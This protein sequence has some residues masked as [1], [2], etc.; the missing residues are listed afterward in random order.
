MLEASSITS[1]LRA[2][3]G[4]IRLADHDP[5]AK[6]GFAGGKRAGE[7]AL[8][9][10]APALSDLKERLFAHRHRRPAAVLLI[11]Q[12]MDTSGK[13]GTVK[14]VLRSGNRSGVRLASFKKPTEEELQHDFLWRIEKQ[15][16][17]LG[18]HRRV[19]PIAVRGRAGRA[20]ASAG[21]I[22]GG[23]AG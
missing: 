6:P 18:F 20:G 1:L 21:S 17:E 10:L 8:L 19:Q 2:P 13:D 23:V 11:L 22:E 4:R 7:Q 16:P 12:G 15:V 14:H 9:A 3:R 5:N